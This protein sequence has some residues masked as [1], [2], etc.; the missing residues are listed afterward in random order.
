M[1]SSLSA[2]LFD[3]SVHRWQLHRPSAT[4]AQGDW[5]APFLFDG[6]GV[7]VEGKLSFMIVEMR[8]E[9]LLGT[10][11][12]LLFV[13]FLAAFV[14][15]RLARNRGP[16]LPDRSSLTPPPPLVDVRSGDIRAPL[17]TNE[18]TR[19]LPAARV[20]DGVAAQVWSSFDPIA[21]RRTYVPAIP[22]GEMLL[23]MEQQRSHDSPAIDLVS[24]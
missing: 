7:S 6:S 5:P 21:R 1:W 9:K 10:A 15:R 4:I 17:P 11:A 2:C 22:N 3:G 23:K 19:R 18:A 14:V 8:W 13:S 20:L 12:F 16:K 24:T